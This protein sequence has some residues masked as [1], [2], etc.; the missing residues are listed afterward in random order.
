M[1][2]RLEGKVVAITG[3]AQGQGR[4]HAIR[5]AEEG[6]DIIA[7]D[8][9]E[10]IP[11][12]AYPLGTQEALDDVVA[13]VEKLDR[14]IVA[15]KADVRERDALRD[16]IDRGVAELGQ[17]DV[18]V[19]NAGII[20]LA[21]RE[22]SAFVDAIDVDLVGVLNLVAVTLP[23]LE[24]G[25]S[26][27]IT[28]STAAMMPGMVE[29]PALGPGGAGY[30]LA[31][32]ILI[33]YSEALALQLAASMIRVNTI[34]PTNVDTNLLHNDQLYRV[35]R[36]DLENPTREDAEMA[37]GVFNAMPVPYV[38]PIDISNAVLFFASAESRYV[39]GVQL[40]VD[41]GSLLRT[42]PLG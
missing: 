32:K 9:C 16:A 21:H 38:D 33:D 23:H 34:H 15:V 30:G 4:S 41:A 8:I 37:F 19:A 36:P 6:A 14:R 10:Q 31:K 40:R 2:G 18:V 29:N 27:V 20:P 26:I 11:S 24:S 5:L 25:A 13:Q 39:T 7:I 17:L 3:A 42:P 35:F 22:P 12:V 1:T 28:G